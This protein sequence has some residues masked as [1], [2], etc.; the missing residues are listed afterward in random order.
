MEFFFYLDSISM[1]T[2]VLKIKVPN[3]L[4]TFTDGLYI[5]YQCE[6]SISINVRSS[7]NYLENHHGVEH[8]L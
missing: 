2:N 8:D 5:N 4:P 3:L 7:Y 1:I 6:D